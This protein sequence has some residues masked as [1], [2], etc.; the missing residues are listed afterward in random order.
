MK[1]A[2]LRSANQYIFSVLLFLVLTIASGYI[3]LRAY[4]GNSKEAKK[5]YDTLLAV[6]AAGG[7]VE[8]ALLSLRTYIYQH[9]NT[10]IGSPTGV[11]PPIQLKGTYDRLVAAEQARVK[12]ANDELY[13]KA[14]KEC[15]R[16]F[17]EGLSGRNRIPCITEFVTKNAVTE[18]TIPDALYK[19]D[20]ASPLWSPDVAGFGIL[21]TA[22][23][24]V[25]FLFTLFTY[26][27]V[28]H[29]KKMSS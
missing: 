2:R 29:H 23:L 5:R 12:Q 26:F 22:L 28:E 24:F 10:T 17:P 19:Y 15:E 14:Q 11:R 13:N 27:R 3:T 20:F 1:T 8:K 9:M 4:I 7:D 16:L 6:D 21:A 25:A 18:Q